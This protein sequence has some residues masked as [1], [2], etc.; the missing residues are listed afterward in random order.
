MAEQDYNIQDVK[1]R[2]KLSRTTI[3]N[4]ANNYATGVQYDTML[5]LCQL[6]SCTPGDLFS[7]IDADIDFEDITNETERNTDMNED[8]IPI[9]EDGNGIDYICEISTNCEIC[10]N[11]SYKE[12]KKAINFKMSVRYLISDERDITEAYAK[13]SENFIRDLATLDMPWFV[14]KYIKK[15]LSDFIITF[16]LEYFSNEIDGE[17][18]GGIYIDFGN[19]NQEQY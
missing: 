7:Y 6:F 8:T 16:G 4:M 15:N 18:L 3:S 5:Q 10:A 1:D 9:D 13:L 12:Q 2:T 17:S 19:G 11:I 14:K